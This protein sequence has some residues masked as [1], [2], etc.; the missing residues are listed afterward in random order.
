MPVGLLQQHN[1]LH[2]R[3]RGGSGCDDHRV[4]L[5]RARGQQ[6]PLKDPA[7]PTSLPHTPHRDCD[8]GGDTGLRQFL[9]KLVNRNKV[10]SDVGDDGD[11]NG[12]VDLTVT[13][14]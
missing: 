13:V 3:A 7:L 12:G 4:E 14:R 9:H 5:D 1:Q 2:V 8:Q 6:R 11:L 10:G